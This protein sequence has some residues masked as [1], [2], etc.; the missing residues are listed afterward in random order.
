MVFLD[1]FNSII[2]EEKG[3]KIFEIKLKESTEYNNNYTKHF[4]DIYYEGVKKEIV[5][6]K[7]VNEYGEIICEID[8]GSLFKFKEI[9]KDIPRLYARFPLIG[10]EDLP[11]KV[12]YNSWRFYVT[13]PRDG[14][15]LFEESNENVKENRKIIEELTNLYLDLVERVSKKIDVYQFIIFYL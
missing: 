14:V 5:F 15:L 7:A 13:E 1:K 11:F 6:L 10:T 9:P 2:I 12:I 8:K 4:L 3:T